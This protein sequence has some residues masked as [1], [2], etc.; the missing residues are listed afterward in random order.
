ME[1]TCEEKTAGE[2]GCILNLRGH[3]IKK[4]RQRIYRKIA[5]KTEMAAANW[6][7][8]HKEGAMSFKT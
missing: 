2:I 8:E 5:W 6:L 4:H 3:T 1:W 7:R